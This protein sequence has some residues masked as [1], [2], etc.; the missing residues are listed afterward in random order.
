MFE[1]GKGSRLFFSGR[2]TSFYPLFFSF[3]FF[4]TPLPSHPYAK[5][6]LQMQVERSASL[7]GYHALPEIDNSL[8]TM[9]AIV[10]RDH[11]PWSWIPRRTAEI[12]RSNEPVVRLRGILT[13]GL[14]S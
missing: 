12:N 3:S 7:A 6:R 11:S 2:R 8:A 13:E 10:T 9:Q 1:T 14:R 5:K 4:S